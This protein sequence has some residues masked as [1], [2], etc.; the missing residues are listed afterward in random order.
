MAH[1]LTGTCWNVTYQDQMI[2]VTVI[3][4]AD[5]D[6]NL[7]EEAMNE[8]T[9]VDSRSFSL[10]PL[11]T[12]TV[13]TAKLIGWVW[14]MELAFRSPIHCVVWIRLNRVD[15]INSSTSIIRRH[16]LSSRTFE[17]P[18]IFVSYFFSLLH[19]AGI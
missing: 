4:H 3:D 19:V 7:A 8:L 2:T 11:L 12:R 18:P 6:Y 15:S 10:T 17:T 9:W 14:L 1:P 16:D 13:A 5:N